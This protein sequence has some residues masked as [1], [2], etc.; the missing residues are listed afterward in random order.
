[1]LAACGGGDA[2][3]G[4]ASGIDGAG[5]ALPVEMH[6]R[7][8]LDSDFPA[9]MTIHEPPEGQHVYEVHS[10]E[11]G[12]QPVVGAEIPDGILH[13]RWGQA[14]RF[15]ALLT[16]ESN[17]AVRFWV[18]PHLPTPYVAQQGLMMFC[19]CTGEV[20]EVPPGGSWTRVMEFGV[21]RRAN[22]EGPIALTHVVVRGEMTAPTPVAADDTGVATDDAG[23]AHHQ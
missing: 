3:D 18:A 8:V 2:A 16:N 14:R 1:M 12:E 5:S 23:M 9:T 20:Y 21:T 13:E 7:W 17:E 22:L 10:Y 4:A 11:A 15:I 19:L 6:V